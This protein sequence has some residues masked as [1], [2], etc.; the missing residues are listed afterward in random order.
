VR[1]YRRRD[2]LIRQLGSF[3]HQK[4]VSP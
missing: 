3:E 1:V 2:R 4:A